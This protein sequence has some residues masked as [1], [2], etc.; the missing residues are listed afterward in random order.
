MDDHANLRLPAQLPDILRAT[1]AHG[2][3]LASEFRTGSLLRTLAATKPGGRFLEIGTGTGV[4]TCWILDGMDANA[5][6]FTVDRDS[7]NAI[8]QTYLG[9]DSRVQ[10]HLGDAEDFLRSMEPGQYDFIFADAGPGKMTFLEEALRGLAPGGIYVVDDLLPEVTRP[11]A[12][13]AGEDAAG[14][15]THVLKHPDPDR[16]ARVDAFIAAIESRDDL[17]LTKLAWASGM[18]IATKR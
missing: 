10:F 15:T 4:G 11:V 7:Q 17:L 16:Q 13:Q 8:A 1:E 18:I 12:S 2:F 3:L 6:L 9:G 14:Q 5:R